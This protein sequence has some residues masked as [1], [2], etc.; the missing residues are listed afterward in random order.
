MKKLLLLISLSSIIVSTSPMKKRPDKEENEK[1]DFHTSVIH[2]RDNPDYQRTEVQQRLSDFSKYAKDKGKNPTEIRNEFGLRLNIFSAHNTRTIIQALERG[3]IEAQRKI[4]ERKA[5]IKLILET[6]GFEDPD[7][8]YFLQ[9][10]DDK[11][12]IGKDMWSLKQR[13]VRMN[14]NI[15]WAQIIEAEKELEEIER[16]NKIYSN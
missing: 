14:P 8:L 12:L 1:T 4:E 5:K 10:A 6:I 7:P 2:E 9:Y 11:D 15:K 13:I 3:R 16:L